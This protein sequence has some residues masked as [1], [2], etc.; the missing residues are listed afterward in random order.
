LNEVGRTH[1]GPAYARLVA[2]PRSGRN[3][4]AQV[5]LWSRESGRAALL[6]ISPSSESWR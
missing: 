5:L 4:K 1:R 2:L 3:D 6:T